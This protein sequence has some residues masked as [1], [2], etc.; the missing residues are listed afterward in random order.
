MPPRW[1]VI[2][3]APPLQPPYQNTADAW[4]EKKK[5]TNKSDQPDVEMQDSSKPKGGG[6]HFTLTIQ[7]MA[8]GDAIQS[9]ILDTVI[10]LPLQDMIGISADLQKR[11]ANLTKTRREYT[12]KTATMSHLLGSIKDHECQSG[13][14]ESDSDSDNKYQEVATTT[15]RLQFSY[16]AHENVE[17]I[18]QHYTSAVPPQAAPL[19]AMATGHFEGSM[20]GNNVTFMID[21]GSELNLMSAEF[22]R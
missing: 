17:D 1:P 3:T 11:F 22:Y 9:R 6:Y 16:G 13:E 19:F 7:D 18:L 8:D 5:A 10:T 15:S 20:A 14:S 21:T 12:Q 2:S 4:K